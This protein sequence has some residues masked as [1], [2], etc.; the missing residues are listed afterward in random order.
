MEL[1]AKLII[2]ENVNK[3]GEPSTSDDDLYLDEEFEKK[4]KLIT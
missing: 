2:D 1:A 4:S 3:E